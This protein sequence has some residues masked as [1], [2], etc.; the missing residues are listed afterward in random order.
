MKCMRTLAP[1]PSV[2]VYGNNFMSSIL[3]HINI[4]HFYVYSRF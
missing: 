1:Y 3:W 4:Y 2:K